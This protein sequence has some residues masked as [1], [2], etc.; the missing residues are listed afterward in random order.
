MK[1]EASY[2]DP[3]PLAIVDIACMISLDGTAEQQ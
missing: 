2:P 3:N 1:I